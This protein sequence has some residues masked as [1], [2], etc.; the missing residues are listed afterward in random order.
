MIPPESTIPEAISVAIDALK[1]TVERE[2]PPRSTRLRIAAA[3][4]RVLVPRL[5]PGRRDH[6][7]D[8][9]YAD[10][11]AGMRGM[12]LFRKHIPNHD[13]LSLWRRRIEEGRLRNT[14]QKRAQRER[15]GVARAD[16]SAVPIVPPTIPR[17]DGH[18]D[19]SA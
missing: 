17:Q 6:R 8:S 10:Y 3:V 13:R 4:R 16:K 1:E 14:L 18:P 11:R 9:A 19:N 7:L 5:K 12:A 15:R 2:N